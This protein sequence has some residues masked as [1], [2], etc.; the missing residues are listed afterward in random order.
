MGKTGKK[1]AKAAPKQVKAPELTGTPLY[2]ARHELFAQKVAKGSS[3]SRAYADVY[4]G[5]VADESTRGNASRLR[6]NE[7]AALRIEELQR[8]AAEKCTVEIA[9]V[10]RELRLLGFA[11]IGRAF[12][13]DGTLMNP[14]DMPE[15]VRRAIAG[16]EV[17]E[18]F[19]GSGP[20]KLQIGYTKKVKFWEKT[21]AIELLGKYL[22]MWTDKV[23]HS[24][25]LTLEQLVAGSKEEDE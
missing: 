25:K 12:K 5:D 2:N 13:E 6:S 9:E 10:I 8:E 17:V 1:K 3:S 19:E 21:K 14:P 24:G 22:K 15:A 4:G 7:I 18:E 20:D 16:F 23:E 11:D